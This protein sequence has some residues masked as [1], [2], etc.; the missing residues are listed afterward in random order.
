MNSCCTSSEDGRF[1]NQLVGFEGVRPHMNHQISRLS[2][3]ARDIKLADAAAAAREICMVVILKLHV[4]PSHFT[5][6]E[7]RDGSCGKLLRSLRIG[8]S[9]HCTFAAIG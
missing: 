7:D 6:R 5:T 9:R 3:A 2:A 4:N 8:H 1:Q